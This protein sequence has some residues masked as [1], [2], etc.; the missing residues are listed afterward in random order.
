MNTIKELEYFAPITPKKFF[1]SSSF[2][3]PTL[4]KPG[5]NWLYVINVKMVKRDNANNKRP[6]NILK[7][8]NFNDPY[9][10]I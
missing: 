6:K 8:N 9:W 2:T 7:A 4:L 1:I 5:S 3:F 10:N